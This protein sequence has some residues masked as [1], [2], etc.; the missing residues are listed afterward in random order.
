MQASERDHAY[1][2]SVD[3]PNGACCCCLN[4]THKHNMK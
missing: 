1:L 4:G 2:E 3:I